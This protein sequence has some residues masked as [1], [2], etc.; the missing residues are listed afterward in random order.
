MKISGFRKISSIDYP[1]KI[2]SVVFTPGCNFS[3]PACH[4][5]YVIE[6]REEYSEESVFSYLD[7][8]KSFV[9]GVVV[10]GGE[11]TSQGDLF[12]FLRKVKKKGFTTKLDTNGSR[13]DILENLLKKE[14]VDYVAMDIKGPNYL[15]PQII[16]KKDFDVKRIERSAKLLSHSRADYEFRTTVVPIWRNEGEGLN[17][18]TESEAKSMAKWISGV[19]DKESKWYLQKFVP[20]KGELIDSRLESLDETSSE[21]LEKMKAEIERYFPNCEIR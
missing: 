10:C 19:A 15:Y 14:L 1:G 8:A 4:A 18:M 12:E 21:I 7:F 16:G 5:K 6:G 11:P 2:S 9:D 17:W 20:R 3:C 13:P